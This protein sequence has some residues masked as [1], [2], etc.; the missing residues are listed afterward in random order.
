VPVRRREQLLAK[1]QPAASIQMGSLTVGRTCPRVIS[2]CKNRIDQMISRH[3]FAFGR[4]FVPKSGRAPTSLLQIRTTVSGF[5]LLPSLWMEAPSEE[6]L[7]AEATCG[8]FF[9]R[10]KGPRPENDAAVVE[11][12]RP[13]CGGHP[14]CARHSR[15]P[16]VLFAFSTKRTDR[17]L[18]GLWQRVAARRGAESVTRPCPRYQIPECC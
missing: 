10:R 13:P 3:L 12:E 8:S 4:L 18:R 1:R 17:F 9:V 2:E 7:R 6:S 5:L 11:K 15:R 16:I 14:K